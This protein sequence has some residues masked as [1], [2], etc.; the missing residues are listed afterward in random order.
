M[1]QI[2]AILYVALSSALTAGA[3]AGSIE[4]FIDSEM[5]AAGVPG[6][7]YAVMT[8]G[9]IA[10]V[11]TRGVVT[12]GGDSEI[13]TETAF[14]SGSISKSFTAL[15][16]MQLVE[17]GAVDLDA[18]VSTY[19]EGFAGQPAGAITIR[20]LL[21][22]TS[23]FSTLQGNASHT[24]VAN[25]KDEL[26]QRVDQRA[27][28][29]PAYEPGERWEY[30]NAN[31]EILGRVIEV[32]SGQEFQAYVE[33]NILEPVGMDDSFV[34]DGEVHESMATGHRP[35]FGTS[36]PLLDNPTDR[37]TA[38]QGGIVASAADLALYMQM[39]MNGE[40]D[41]LS[42]AGKEQMMRPASAISP[43]YGFGWW[44]D[45][46][47][48]SVWHAGSTPGFES[49]ATMVPGENLGV[50]VLVN[51][52]SGIGF[53]ET[54]QLR[55]GITAL[56][57]GLEYE[58][59]GSRWSQKALFVALVL[60]PVI[61]VLSMVWAWRHRADLRAKS[62]AFGLFSLWFP[63][64]TTLVAAWVIVYLVPAMIGAPIATIR[65]FQPDLGL[66]LIASAVT[67]VAWA[68]FRLGVAYSGRPRS[69]VSTSGG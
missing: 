20:Q 14:Q 15:A 13:T 1:L 3:P 25:A 50:V 67:G 2:L 42:A 37:G 40:D 63:L 29:E 6:L 57:L 12:S 45:P 43:Y 39:M 9:D 36:R 22:H 46:E 26:E 53:G 7:A 31:Y 68:V 48:G 69:S 54:T 21:S 32:V 28:E 59:E 58:G 5:P 23:G 11:D 30:S 62:G 17:A 34:A 24:D 19:L 64:L 8:D 38:P 35:W 47:R 61:Y 51:A 56:A 44:L 52:G 65:L 33:A 16:V 66:V 18:E 27:E 55:N 49:L 4:E 10:G 60:L 41:V